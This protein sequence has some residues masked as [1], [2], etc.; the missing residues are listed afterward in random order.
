ML[1]LLPKFHSVSDPEP[2]AATHRH[3]PAAFFTAI[4]HIHLGPHEPPRTYPP[5]EARYLEDELMS[6]L[7]EHL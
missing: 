5:H 7:M 6:R 4:G 1:H 2:P 3:W